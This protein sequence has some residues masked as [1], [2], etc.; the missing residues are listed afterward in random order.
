MLS[1][2]WQTVVLFG[3]QIVNRLKLKIP[4]AFI[5]RPLHSK[6]DINRVAG[7]QTYNQLL[8]VIGNS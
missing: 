1:K 8:Y 7:G 6:Y 3:V 2:F 4:S 5:K